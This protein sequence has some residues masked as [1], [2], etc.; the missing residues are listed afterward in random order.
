[1]NIFLSSSFSRSYKKV[2]RKNPR[3]ERKIKKRISLFR[4]YP[5]HPSLKLYKLT[6]SLHETWSFSIEDD[7]RILFTYANDGVIFVDIGKHEEVY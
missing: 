4:E 6:G 3:L 1:M 2:L 7:V 5:E